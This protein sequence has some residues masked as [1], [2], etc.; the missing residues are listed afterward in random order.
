MISLQSKGFSK[1][2]PPPQYESMSSLVLSLPY[3]STETFIHD[4]WK[5]D[6]CR[7][8]L[9]LFATPWTIASQAPLSMEFSRQE[10]WSGLLFPTPG[11]LPNLGIKATSPASPALT[12]RFFT[13]EK[14]H[15]FLTTNLCQQSDI[16]VFLI[17]CLGFLSLSFFQ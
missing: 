2:S 11:D 8:H 13:T 6:M 1:A 17:H 15:N 4:Y 5:D 10:Y 16:S 3:G 14:T 7:S 12:G 9:R